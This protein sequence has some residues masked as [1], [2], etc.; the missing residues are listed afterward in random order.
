MCAS[1]QECGALG[2]ICLGDRC[3]QDCQRAPCP[4][5][6]ECTTTPDGPP[7]CVPAAGSCLCGPE[8]FGL[9]SA[10]ASSNGFGT[11]WGTR[12]CGPGGLSTCT[13][14][15][16]TREVCNGRDDDCD[17]LLDAEDPS[18]DV[19]SL[20]SNPAFPACQIGDADNCRGTWACE[21]SGWRC[22]P[23]APAVEVCD[24]LDKECNGV[25]D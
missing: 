22:L 21:A 12:T 14:R 1:S 23:N 24:G 17:G 9:E 4:D 11:C 16:P 6:Y 10:C 7:Q 15:A 3:T 8:A 25:V 20:P 13:A 5:G 2:G 19:S 18:V